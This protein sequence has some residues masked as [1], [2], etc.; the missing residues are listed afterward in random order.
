MPVLFRRRRTATDVGSVHAE[1]TG[2][3]TDSLPQLAS[4]AIAVTAIRIA[5]VDQPVGQTFEVR[6]EIGGYD[7]VLARADH[8]GEGP[9][10]ARKSVIEGGQG[11]LVG[12]VD[13]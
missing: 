5:D 3:L 2:D 11:L 1:A 9:R 8:L 13:K 12:S 4:R 10:L 7:L 6:R